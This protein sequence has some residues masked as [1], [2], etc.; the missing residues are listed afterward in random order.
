MV[1]LTRIPNIQRGNLAQQ[2]LWLRLGLISLFTVVALWVSP[3]YNAVLLI[4]SGYAASSVLLAVGYRIKL[5]GSTDVLYAGMLDTSLF[6]GAG[7][8]VTGGYQSP[9][10]FLFFGTQAAFLVLAQPKIFVVSSLLSILVITASVLLSGWGIIPAVAEPQQQPLAYLL[11][12]AGALAM[13]GVM[14]SAHSVIYVARSQANRHLSATLNALRRIVRSDSGDQQLASILSNLMTT[15]NLTDEGAVYRYE[16]NADSLKL[17]IGLGLKPWFQNFSAFWPD[18]GPVGRAYREKRRMVYLGAEQLLQHLG[19]LSQQNSDTLANLL[20]KN[21]PPSQTVAVPVQWRD[22]ALGALV[23]NREN[24]AFDDNELQLIEGFS[25]HLAV[26]MQQTS[27]NRRVADLE[28]KVNTCDQ[29]KALLPSLS[30]SNQG[31]GQFVQL[32]KQSIPF[33]FA[34]VLATTDGCIVP[35]LSDVWPL[36]RAEDR[37]EFDRDGLD[38]YLGGF[39]GDCSPETVFFVSTDGAQIGLPPGVVAS[40]LP[41]DLVE[42]GIGSLLGIAV[43]VTDSDGTQST[44]VLALVHRESSPYSP[45][46]LQ[47]LHAARP[48]FAA[49]IGNTTKTVRLEQKSRQLTLLSN[50]VNLSYSGADEDKTVKH[51]LEGVSVQL[52]GSSPASISAVLF[53]EEKGSIT[54]TLWSAANPKDFQ[55][56][57]VGERSGELKTLF[58][59]WI[60]PQPRTFSGDETD[61]QWVRELLAAPNEAIIV[62]HPVHAAGK[63]FGMVGVQ[64]VAS[65][66]NA[67]YDTQSIQQFLDLSALCLLNT[68]RHEAQARQARELQQE[69]ELRR[70]F[71]SYITHEFRTPLASLKTSFELIQEAE[72]MRGLDDPYQRLLINV[73]RSIATLGELIN[74]MAEVANISAGGVVLD[75]TETAPES[76][77]YPVIETTSP[78][79]HL[80]SQ[81]LE[82]EIRPDLPKLMAD[83]H[84]LEQVLT[85]MVSNAIKY[86]P[87]GGTIKTVVSRENG[88][89]KF[90]VSDTGRGI[91]KEDLDKVFDPFYRVPQQ[92]S[93]RTPGT[94]L[95]LALAKSLV[96][97]H[98]GNIWV[99]SE[100]NKGSTFFFT[101][102]IE[103]LRN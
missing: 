14:G 32:L 60:E 35:E 2:S 43:E 42:Q 99:E 23:L 28:R 102:P 89:I 101:I 62:C 63:T 12:A 49:A 20:Q 26:V 55:H 50:L 51:I 86:T 31:I 73:N 97:L 84:R 59:Q 45:D 33:E 1:S 48:F 22:Q 17:E 34:R 27:A 65:P 25:A 92:S 80:K 9:V 78:L 11:A 57:P 54:A 3:G 21:K 64:I 7:V 72:V 13:L 76:I 100:P 10:L 56:A 39:L 37:V 8:I 93:D 70:S 52:I 91:P 4:V 15:L 18:E 94:G 47:L 38:S 83:S 98:G 67:Q 68:R 74:D 44:G 16:P 36:Q 88:S 66:A 19:D 30:D 75:K 41:P 40:H 61:N 77:I 81:S 24:A 6:L 58:H 95:G 96:E 53:D 29:L 103:E 85:N 82:V 90:A 87:P 46:Q 69:D 71:L 79:S 5:L